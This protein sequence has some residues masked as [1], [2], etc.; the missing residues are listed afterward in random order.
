MAAVLFWVATAV[1]IYTYVGFPILVL[2]R[3]RIRPRP[4]AR[5]DIT[6]PV[7]VIIAA[8]DEEASIGDRVDNLLALDY[9]NDKLEIVIGS[10]GSTDRTVAE[11]RRRDDARVHVLDLSRTGK[12]TALNRAVAASSGEI[13]VFS[14]ANTAYATNAIGVLVRSFAD[15]TVGGVAGN[16]VYLPATAKAGPGDPAAATAVGVGERSY[17]DF[18]RIVKDAES[19]GGS[20]ISA[21]G[22]MYAI[23][24]ELFREVPNGVTD[25][26]VTSTRVI[27]AR[28]RLVFEPAA[29]AYEPVAG[30]SGREYSRKVRIMTR[31]LRGVAVARELL[32][33]GRHGFYAL[34]LFT[35]KILRRLMAIPLL[36]ILVT[37]PFLWDEGP[38]YRVAVVGQLLVYGLGIVGLALRDHAMGRRPWFAIPAFFLLV[39]IASLHALWNLLSGRRIDRWQPA[40]RDVGT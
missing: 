30:S 24:R 34:Q 33:P 11:A 15:P 7:S 29:V 13:L 20:V 14:D 5:A 26:F 40:R 37:S 21:T 8:H 38:I 39:N 4:H 28:R 6:P 31:G 25:D 2:L 23:R 16:Q 19:L 3:A 18:D 12:A 1:V 17:W 22:A 36:V 9:P 32:D 10:D 35:H 27:A